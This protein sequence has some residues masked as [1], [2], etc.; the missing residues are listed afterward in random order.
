[1][2]LTALCKD[3]TLAKLRLWQARYTE[4]IVIAALCGPLFLWYCRCCRQCLYG[5]LF[6]LRLMTVTPLL[7]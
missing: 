1:M 7:S 4:S 5:L 2:E 6:V 3:C